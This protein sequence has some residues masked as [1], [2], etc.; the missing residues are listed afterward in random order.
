MYFRQV[1]FHKLSVS[2]GCELGLSLLQA[3]LIYCILLVPESVSY[4][5]LFLL[6]DWYL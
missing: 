4:L 2:D 5:F 3:I 1:Y 6:F